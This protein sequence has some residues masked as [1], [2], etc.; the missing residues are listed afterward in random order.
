MAVIICVQSINLS[1]KEASQ[2][3]D[4]NY[5]VVMKNDLRMVTDSGLRRAEKGDVCLWLSAVRD[6]A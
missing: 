2:E 4:I 6:P 1:H 3:W 5:P